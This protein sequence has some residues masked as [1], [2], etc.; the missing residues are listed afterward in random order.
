MH[1]GQ[2]VSVTAAWEGPSVVGLFVGVG[3]GGGRQRVNV[4]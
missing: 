3:S 4:M 1:K 2:C